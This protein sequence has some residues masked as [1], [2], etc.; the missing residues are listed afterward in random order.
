MAA[1]LLNFKQSGYVINKKKFL[2]YWTNKND[3]GMIVEF[4][5]SP[6]PFKDVIHKQKIGGF[7][8]VELFHTK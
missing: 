5:H 7:Q 8:W 1:R 4:F 2:L 3:P 6:Y